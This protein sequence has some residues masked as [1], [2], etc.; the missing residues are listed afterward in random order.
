MRF[1]CVPSTETLKAEAGQ[2]PHRFI[3]VSPETAVASALA[4]VVTDPHTLGEAP[5]VSMPEH[6][7]VNDNLIIPPAPEGECVKVVR[8]PNIQPFPKN[9]KVPKEIKG[10]ALIK[11]EDNITT[12]HIMPSQREAS[13]LPFQCA[14][15]GRL[16][17]DPLRP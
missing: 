9:T 12:D 11:V 2:N 15:S 6:F 16:L 8:G 13:S 17:P 5:L 7:M 4:G 10:G 14:L 3:F 1:P